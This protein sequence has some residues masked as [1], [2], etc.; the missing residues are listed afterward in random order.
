LKSIFTIVGTR[1][2]IVK[3]AALTRAIKSRQDI[4]ER[5]IHTGQH[6]DQMMSEVFFDDLG[7]PVPETN[8][9]IRGGSHADMT[10]AMMKG[11]EDIMISDPRDGVIVYGDTNSTLAGALTAAKLNIPVI[12][13]EAGLRS[14]N[15]RMPE[16]INR[17]VTDHL[18][19]LL[20]CPTSTARRN[21]GNEGIDQGVFEPG[22]VM[23][24]V[25]LYFAEKAEA[26]SS[27][28]TDLGLQKGQYQV[29]T[30][31]RA[32]NTDDPEMLA[33]LLSYLKAANKVIPVVIPLHPRTRNAIDRDDLD[34]GSL[35]ICQPLG[36]LDMACLIRGAET[37]LTD[38]GGLQKEAYFHGIPC[39]TLRNETEWVE[40]IDAGWN[41]LWTV[42]DY[43]SREPIDEYGSGNAAE[44]IA[45]IIAEEL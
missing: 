33:K 38:S 42:D 18:S 13:I 30:V 5:L 4:D 20:F 14:F 10:A 22:D 40:T 44:K 39:I 37:V 28:I 31:H 12:H 9:G 45:G 6:F 29:A 15:R 17:I 32:E 1:P 36:Y 25:C 2:Q 34:L 41:R 11:L 27:I 8:L 24:D 19:T 35:K 16:E 3:A 23:Y 7:I 21:L 26:D 43:V